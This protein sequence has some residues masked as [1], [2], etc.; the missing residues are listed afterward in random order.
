MVKSDRLSIQSFISNHLHRYL[1]L[2]SIILVFSL[3]YPLLWYYAKNKKKYFSQLV[4]LRRWIA[5]KSTFLVGVRFKIDRE[6]N[7]DTSKNYI[8]CANH[9]SNLDISALM[10]V[11]DTDFSFIGKHELLENKV[12]SLF[13]KTIDIPINRSSKISSFRAFKK[14]QFLLE[15]GKSVALFPE[16]GINDTFPPQLGD[17]KIGAFKLAVDSNIP[18]L[19]VII[20]DSWKLCWDDGTAYGT[21]PGTCHITVLK[22]IEPKSFLNAESLREQVY[23][24]FQNNLDKDKRNNSDKRHSKRKAL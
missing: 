1:Y 24:I 14:A 21:S 9:A 3:A 11:W 22:P 13:F 23:S 8:I 2:V 15:S 7:I 19:P 6:I 10:A 17:F 18:I 4:K 20:H 16:G 12:T 5:L